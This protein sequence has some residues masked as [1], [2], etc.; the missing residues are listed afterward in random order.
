MIINVIKITST[1]T[2]FIFYDITTKPIRHYFLDLKKKIETGRYNC[3]SKN[4]ICYEDSKITLIKT[5]DVDNEL[6]FINNKT[7]LLRYH[8]TLNKNLDNVIDEFSKTPKE[9][10]KYNKYNKEKKHLYYE[11][12]KEKLKEKMLNRYYEEYRNKRLLHY[13]EHKY[14]IS[15]KRKQLYQD[16]Y[17]S[18]LEKRKIN[19]EK[20]KE[21]KKIWYEKKK[22]IK[23]ILIKEER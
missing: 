1:N 9:K 7:M 8:I 13:E 21:Y 14:E 19:K 11:Q 10:I 17:K 12:N 20:I 3:D 5:F 6:E 23:Q 15:L 22:E 4:V 2:D 18:I 16:N